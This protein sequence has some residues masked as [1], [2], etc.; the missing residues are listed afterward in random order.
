MQEKITTAVNTSFA[1]D[2]HQGLTDFP[3]HLSSK[4]F[5]DERGDRL[6]QDIMQM[7]EYYLTNSEFEILSEQKDSII[8]HF[9]EG[10]QTINLIELG[11]GDGKKTKILLKHMVSEGVD[12]R[13]LPIDISQ[14]ALDNLE[15]SINDEI[16]GVPIETKQGTY[17]EV[18]N[19][20]ESFRSGKKVI[21]FLGSNIG[22][23]LHPEAVDFLRQLRN[24]MVENDL[25]FIGFDQ[26]K[27]PQMV[28]DA[29]NDPAGITAAFNKNVLL[30][31]N[32]ELGGNFDLDEFRHWEVYDPESGTAKSYLVSLSDQVVKISALDL[33]VQFRPWETIHTEISQKYDDD[34][35]SWLAR[36]SGLTIEAIFSTKDQGYKN[37]LLKKGR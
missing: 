16:K 36:E 35:V 28:L 32:R 19:H 3:K 9:E 21:L 7:P 6:F 18:L 1:E 31:I 33:E 23:L 8:R 15:N 13:Y 26:K 5:Y 4:Y 14:N 37:Y 20:L 25:L 12:F 17:F 22:N 27:D 30:R 2:V 34:V 11:A 29:Y 10:G 24:V